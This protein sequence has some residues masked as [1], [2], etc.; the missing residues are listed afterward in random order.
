M[1]WVEARTD[2]NRD[3][4]NEEGLKHQVESNIA[5]QKAEVKVAAIQSRPFRG[6]GFGLVKTY[7]I[8]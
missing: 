2:A 8:N 4:D 7:Q 5:E 3:S 1:T 6:Q